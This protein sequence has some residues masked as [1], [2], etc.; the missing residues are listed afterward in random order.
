VDAVARIQGD[1]TLDDVEDAIFEATAYRPAIV[2]VNKMD[3]IDAE[4]KLEEL[5]EFAKGRIRIVPVSCK[6]RQGLESLGKELFNALG[7]IRVYTKELGT[8][9]P[10][11]KPFILK[12][13][14]TIQDLARLIHSDFFTRFSSARIWS[15]RLTFS[16]QKVGLSFVLDDKDVV[17]IHV[18]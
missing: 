15:K 2:V 9:K 8:K 18:K 17:E 3:F 13:A 10:S 12:R 7:I 11:P 5:K 4:K 16:P 1:A 6:T 14:A